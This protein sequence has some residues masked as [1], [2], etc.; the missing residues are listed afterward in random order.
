MGKYART[1]K[2]CSTLEM[3]SFYGTSKMET[4]CMW[5]IPLEPTHPAESETLTTTTRREKDHTK[6]AVHKK[7]YD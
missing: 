7:Y 1:V 4:M 3:A 2:L 6:K 5:N